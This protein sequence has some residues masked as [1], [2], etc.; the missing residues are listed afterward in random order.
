MKV[1]LG[2]ALA[3]NSLPDCCI[4]FFESPLRKYHTNKK[5]RLM[6]VLFIGGHQTVI[7]EH[8]PAIQH[9]SL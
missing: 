7:Y 8:F 4:E 6:A 3:S 2:Q 9:Q 5:Y 1:L